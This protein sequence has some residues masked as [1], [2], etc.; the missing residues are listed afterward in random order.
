MLHV[1]FFVLIT[2]AYI[3]A[4][5]LPESETLATKARFFL[6]VKRELS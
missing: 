4:Q 6:F 3:G 1:E 5:R 2:G